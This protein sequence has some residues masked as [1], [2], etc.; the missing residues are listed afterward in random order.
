[1]ADRRLRIADVWLPILGLVLVL[2]GYFGPWVP[3]ETAGLT[4]TG[5]EVAEFAKLFNSPRITREL[6][7][8]PPLAA[9]IL[10]GFLINRPTNKL[11]IRLFLTLAAALPALAALP[12]YQFLRDPGYH[13]QLILTVAGVG[14]TLLTFLV[15]WLPRR[16]WGALVSLVALAGAVPA[17]WQFARF[18]PLVITLYDGPVGVGWGLILCAAGFALLLAGGVL[19]AAGLD[20]AQKM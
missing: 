7:F 4:V 12:P 18:H 2:A 11:L 19:V 20:R 17:L 15:G 6:F 14:L 10:L 16:I 8:T 13:R 3:H 1:M 5:A 9:A